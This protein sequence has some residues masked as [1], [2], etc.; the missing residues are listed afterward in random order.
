MVQSGTCLLFCFDDLALILFVLSY[1]CGTL[2]YNDTNKIVKFVI[3]STLKQNVCLLPSRI[4]N[5]RAYIR[6]TGNGL[7]PDSG[8]LQYIRL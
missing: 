5:Q 3:I 8:L 7:T 4:S 6:Q 1:L 2:K